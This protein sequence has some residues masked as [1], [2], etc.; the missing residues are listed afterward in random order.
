MSYTGKPATSS[1]KLPSRLTTIVWG[2][3]LIAL[4]G[5]TIALALGA[6]IDTQL[7]LIA[8]LGV[9]GVLLVGVSLFRTL[10]RKDTSTDTSSIHP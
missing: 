5:A 10:R 9:T 7:G 8:L 2:V 6:T 4:G 1:K 3:I